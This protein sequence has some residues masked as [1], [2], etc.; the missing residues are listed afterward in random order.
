MDLIEDST[1]VYEYN[2]YARGREDIE[3]LGPSTKIVRNRTMP[4][5][6]RKPHEFC[7]LMHVERRADGSQIMLTRATDHPQVP[8]SQDY[9][10][11]EILL[12]V[13]EV[14]PHASNP[15]QTQ[16]LTISHVK[17]HG[18]PPLIADRVSAQGLAEYVANL[19]AALKIKGAVMA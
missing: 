3:K 19:E 1:R 16:F 14:R 7:T 13:T 4:P 6:S 10:R 17:S 18:V 12:G 8:R 15:N 11:S 5:F 2:R 9:V